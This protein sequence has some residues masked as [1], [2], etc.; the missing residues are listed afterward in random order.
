MLK[1]DNLASYKALESAEM[2]SV[3]GGFDPFAYCGM[4][5]MMSGLM[6]PK[7]KAPIA[8]HEPTLSLLPTDPVSTAGYPDDAIYVRDS[9]HTEITNKKG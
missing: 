5:H 9:N 2:K 7:G 4:S 1:I 6:E 8:P 3:V